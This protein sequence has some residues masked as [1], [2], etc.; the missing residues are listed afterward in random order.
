GKVKRE[1]IGGGH[2]IVLENKWGRPIHVPVAA[3]AAY[4]TTPTLPRRFE[5][6]VKA[7]LKD[8]KSADRLPAPA[9]WAPE[10]GLLPQFQKMI[11]ELK[12]VAPDNAT[13]KLVLKARDALKVTPSRD[14]PAAASLAEELA[15]ESYRPVRSELGHYTLLTNARNAQSDAA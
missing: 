4:I 8:G 1:E 12:A 7:D 5:H 13:L 11:D 10:R 2:C 6:K 9:A 15:R 3:I 14:D